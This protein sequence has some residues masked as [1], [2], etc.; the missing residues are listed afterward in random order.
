MF[1]WSSS[2][3]S[4]EEES[5]VDPAPVTE[6]DLRTAPRLPPS[7]VPTIKGLRLLP[8]G[9][10]ATLINIS[11]S[12]LLAECQAR[13]KAGS[14]VTVVFEGGFAPRSISARVIRATVSSLGQRGQ[15]HYHVGLLFA[16][17]IELDQEG[18]APAL[19]PVNKPPASPP[20]KNRW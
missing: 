12:G 20:V 4:K 15:L 16:H 18:A 3:A 10:D 2:K 9:A 5:P 6:S 19:P 1:G 13:I 7:A 14:L 17:K 8:P 11:T